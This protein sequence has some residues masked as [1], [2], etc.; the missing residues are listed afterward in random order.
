LTVKISEQLAAYIATLITLVVVLIIAFVAVAISTN[1]TGK[2]EAF[3]LG[4]V[5]GGLIGLLRVPSHTPPSVT[6]TTD[7]AGTATVTSAP[8]PD[9]TE[10]DEKG[11]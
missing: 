6:A 3:A 4:T 2:L 8:L 10:S 11:A 1:V 5:M 9:I 7:G